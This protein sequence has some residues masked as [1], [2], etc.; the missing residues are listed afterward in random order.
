MTLGHLRVAFARR[1]EVPAFLQTLDF[2]VAVSCED[3]DTIIG[4]A[5]LKDTLTT[6]IGVWLEASDD[7][8]AQ[9][10]ARDVKTLSWLVTLSDVVVVGENAAAQA[11][12]VDALMTNDEV[13]FAN[14][15]ATLRG[16]YNRPAP[17][18]PP[19]VWWLEENTLHCGND[20]LHAGGMV[21]NELGT[22][23]TYS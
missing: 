21:T 7:Y 17:P 16:A 22:F 15:V 8:L 12:V 23:E 2:A 11:A 18:H 10:I 6:P 4:V 5:A 1:G 13:N 14:E 9:M 3:A 19:R 20:V